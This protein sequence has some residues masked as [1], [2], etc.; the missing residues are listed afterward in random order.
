MTPETT[1]LARP[2]LPVKTISGATILRD[3]LCSK[4]TALIRE[5][6]SRTGLRID[7][8][9]IVRKEVKDRRGYRTKYANVGA[10]VRLSGDGSDQGGCI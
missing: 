5:Y 3:E 7:S 2:A 4:L 10:N 9:G 8:L 1:I 6:E